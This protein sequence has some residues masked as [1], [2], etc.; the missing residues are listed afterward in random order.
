MAIIAVLF[1]R[2][3][4]HFLSLPLPKLFFSWPTLFRASPFHHP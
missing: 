1:H 3:S 2:H 4:R